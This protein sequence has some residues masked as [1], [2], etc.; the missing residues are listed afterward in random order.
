MKFAYHLF[1][2]SETNGIYFLEIHNSI[3]SP[4]D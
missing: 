1:Y 2:K 4:T 3:D